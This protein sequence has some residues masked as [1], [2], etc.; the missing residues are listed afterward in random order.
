MPNHMTHTYAYICEYP[1]TTYCID[2]GVTPTTCRRFRSKTSVVGLLLWK[3]VLFTATI[4][5]TAPEHH[6]TM[7]YVDFISA[8]VFLVGVI[9][10]LYSW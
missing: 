5:V 9:Y 1:S 8:P 7:L 2:T 10:F 4:N 3:R 6:V